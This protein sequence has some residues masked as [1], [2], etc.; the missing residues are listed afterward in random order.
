MKCRVETQFTPE[1]YRELVEEKEK[2]GLNWNKCIVVWM[3]TSKEVK[4]KMN[5]KVSKNG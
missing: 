2:L 5:N 3:R 4:E 1:E